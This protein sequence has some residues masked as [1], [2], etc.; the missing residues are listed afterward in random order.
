MRMKSIA[1]TLATVVL[2]SGCAVV[3]D[4]NQNPY[5]KPPFYAQFLNTGSDLDARMQQTLQAL[6]ATPDSAVLHNDLG[7]MLMTKDFPRDAQREFERAIN[8]DSDFY[9]AW[10]NLGLVRAAQG[11]SSGAKR[12]FRRTVSLRKGHPPALFQLGLM[13]EKRGDVETAVAYYAKAFRH[14]PAMLDVRVNPAILDSKL[15]HL[16]LLHKYDRDRHRE[17]AVFE[18]AYPGYA[19]AP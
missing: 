4:R 13:A 8:A 9:P 12:A 3:R 19:P 10:Y 14:N 16:A 15:T 11:N 5:E 17:G 2:L 7:A 6:R 1:L 18:P